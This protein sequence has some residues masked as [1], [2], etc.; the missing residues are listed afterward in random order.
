MLIVWENCMFI[1][2]HAKI[3][4]DTECQLSLPNIIILSVPLLSGVS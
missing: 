1:M 4:L 2:F 3:P